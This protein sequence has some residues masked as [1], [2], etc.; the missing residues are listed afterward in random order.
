L[1][2]EIPNA[3]AFQQPRLR[4]ISCLAPDAQP[5]PQRSAVVPHDGLDVSQPTQN[6]H[7]ERLIRTIKEEEVN[8]AEYENYQ[9][10]YRQIGCFIEDVYM[11]KRIYS[12]LGY[13]T[14]PEFE[15][16]WQSILAAEATDVIL[17]SVIWCPGFGAHCTF[18]SFTFPPLQIEPAKH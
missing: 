8:L 17:E 14:M 10:A 9:D 3:A 11:Y 12:S 4:S 18:T 13:L 1:L 6:P 5:P 2:K 7:V 16:Q 15:C